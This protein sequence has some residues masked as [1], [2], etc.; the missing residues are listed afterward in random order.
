[1]HVNDKQAM[2]YSKM[3]SCGRKIEATNVALMVLM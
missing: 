2:N 1:M 3:T